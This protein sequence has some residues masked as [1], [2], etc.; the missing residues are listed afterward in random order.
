MNNQHSGQSTKDSRFSGREID[1][2]ERLS[3]FYLYSLWNVKWT[4]TKDASRQQLLL[5]DLLIGCQMD[6]N[7]F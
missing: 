4:K 7:E 1:E 3:Y 5:S 2:N 6:E